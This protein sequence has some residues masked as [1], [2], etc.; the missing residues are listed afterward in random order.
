MWGFELLLNKI[1]FSVNNKILKL[2]NPVVNW[3]PRLYERFFANIFPSQE[4]RWVF[5]V[6]KKKEERKEK[7]EEYEEDLSCHCPYQFH[8]L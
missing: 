3:Y 2:F 7:K 4:I 5:K 1:D 6:V 8:Q